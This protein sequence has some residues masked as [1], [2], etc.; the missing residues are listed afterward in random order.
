MK[1]LQAVKDTNKVK[2]D[3]RDRKILS[4]LSANSRTPLTQL[5]KKVGLSRDAVKYRIR[6][7]EKVGLIQGYRALVDIS[8]FGYDNYH[9]FIKLNNPSEETEKQIICKIAKLSFIRAIIKFGGSYD[10]EIAIIAKDIADLDGKITKLINYCGNLIQESEMLIISKTFV[11]ET[12][13]KNFLEEKEKMQM[14]IFCKKESKEIKVDK[15]DIQILSIIAENA[16]MQIVD[17]ADKVRI[18]PDSV[19]YRIKNMLSSGVI[20]KFIPVINYSSLDYSLYAVLLDINSF[21]EEKEERILEF[22]LNNPNTLWAVKTIGRY[23]ILIYLLVKN[24]EELQETIL[25]MRGLF[26]KEIK[27]YQILIG[28]EEYKYTYFPKELF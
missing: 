15:K 5:S 25:K 10:F 8:K 13:P 16:N 23:N 28:Y 4:L 14:R 24:T 26:P 17:I 21:D 1:Y 2:L 12:F 3:L 22:L 6:N 9:L 18:S 11:A 27:D 7:Y 19:T 20:K